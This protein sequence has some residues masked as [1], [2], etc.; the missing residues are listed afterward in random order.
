MRRWKAH[1][2]GT[3]VDRFEVP[4]KHRTDR[5]VQ[6]VRVRSS[7]E[8][9]PIREM[10]W[11]EGA[12]HRLKL[13]GIENETAPSRISRA[14]LLGVDIGFIRFRRRPRRAALAFHLTVED[15]TAE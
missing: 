15:E 14:V 2:T 7:N 3:E 5:V 8:R 13:A 12:D 11:S 6:T 4:R 9:I 10:A 1:R